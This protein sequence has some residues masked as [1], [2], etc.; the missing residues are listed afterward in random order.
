M[1]VNPDFRVVFMSQKLCESICSVLVLA[2]LLSG[3]FK[4]GEDYVQPDLSAYTGTEWK[5]GTPLLE[6][7]SI[8]VRWWTQFND[9][10]LNRLVE[11]LLA[12]NISL[13]VARER[14]IEN[15][16]QRGVTRAD[17]LPKAYLGGYGLRS[18][19]ADDARGI[20]GLPGGTQSNL[21][22]AAALAGWELDLW[23]RVQRLVESADYTIE[24]SRAAYGD[25]AVSLV[26]ELALGY[27][28]LRATEARI[29]LAQR[30][31]SLLEEQ[32]TLAETK[33]IAGTGTRQDFLQAR[34]QVRQSKAVLRTLF[35]AKS[36]AENSMAVLLGMPPSLFTC[37]VGC[38]LVPPSI[39]GIGIPASLL[40]RRP[41]IRKAEQEYAA[42][43]ALVGAAK[44]ER[45]PKIALGGTLNFQGTDVDKLFHADT[46]VYAFGGGVLL[47][48]FTGGRIEAQ[49]EV[50]ESLAE[51]RKLQLQQAVLEAVEEVENS[52]IGVS[53]RCR[54]TQEL[55]FAL[56]ERSGAVELTM[57]L[58]ASG[59]QGLTAV[60]EQQLEQVSL[61]DALAVAR[62]Q[63][64][65]EIIHLYRALGGGWDVTEHAVVSASH[66]EHQ[67]E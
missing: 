57:K 14:I 35:Q 59:L 61:A 27:V 54:Q 7:E 37:A 15:R 30:K 42:S 49:I 40:S 10:E 67:S 36:V 16:S 1:F 4:V 33:L 24:A 25:A 55:S 22:A 13:K 58:F 21:F 39:V 18:R 53:Q 47:P 28:D 34:T 17:L 41:D 20:I 60:V 64:L 29:L 50:Q 44:G 5:A 9:V 46:L 3:C 32:R 43:V 8:A 51:Q 65:G 12:Q 56:Q 19:A 6:N 66:K 31:T 23:G 38:Q 26:A 2:A 52:V 63:E 11:T 45:F 62:Q 48:V